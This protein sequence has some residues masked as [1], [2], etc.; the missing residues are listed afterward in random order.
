MDCWRWPNR[1]V[2]GSCGSQVSA[3]SNGRTEARRNYF[4]ATM[5]MACAARSIL[6]LGALQILD[7]LVVPAV[8][9]GSRASPPA[10]P[11]IGACYIVAASPTGAWVGKQQNL[12]AYSSGGWR[13]IAPIEGMTAYVRSSSV[14]AVYRTGAWELGILRG[15]NVTIGGQQ[16][17]GA[18]SSAIAEPA[19][20]SVVDTEARSAV[21]Q[22]LSALRL[23]GLIET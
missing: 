15:S 5:P 20:G 1:I 9:E 21:G 10:S 2:A 4:P 16:V 3:G 18:R 19:G 8:E 6:S 23:H 11:A 13:F 22:I 14:W 12:A 17:I 7:T